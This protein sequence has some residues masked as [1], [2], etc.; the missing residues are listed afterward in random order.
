[1]LV[2]LIILIRRLYF[3]FEFIFKGADYSYSLNLNVGR[4]VVS[5][6]NMFSLVP[7][8]LLSPNNTFRQEL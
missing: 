1:M 7:T 5:T 8:D 3:I 2:Y 6:K 4:E